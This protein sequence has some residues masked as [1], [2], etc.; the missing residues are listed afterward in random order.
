[1]ESVGDLLHR[2]DVKRRQAPAGHPDL[3]IARL[4]ERQYGVV[5][6]RQ[7]LELGFG[8]LVIQRRL[9]SGRLHLIHRGVYAVGHQLL[10]Q[11]GRWLAAVLAVGP[12]AALS[13]R[14]AAA[15]WKMATVPAAP[16]EVIVSNGSRRRR[17]GIII[18]R[19]TCV[20]ACDVT[21]HKG[22]P[23]TTPTRT[24]IDLATRVTPREL[25]DALDEAQRLRLVT[26]AALR[27]RCN[28]TT[29]IRGTGSLRAL[30][31][32]PR[33][34][35]DD[36]KSKLEARFLGFCRQRGLQIPAVNVPLLDYEV[37]CLWREQRVVGELDGWQS[38]RSRVAFEADRVRD[39]RV[40]LG[41]Y[42][43]IRITDLRIDHGD[44]LESDL[45][46]LLS[47]Q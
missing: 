39:A 18:H 7:L 45:R 28:A 15:L 27:R 2:G 38:H 31:D 19:S 3:A 25:R 33:I 43:V 42:S 46:G 6:R 1:M 8:R 12:G 34:P 35:L 44:A 36:A 11:Y 9:E 13:H 21:V 26:R 24:L 14:R 23:V 47:R 29:G 4:A 16:I 41:G 40:Q 22:I 32:E 30:L 17:Q 5:A 20:E 37:D 10:S